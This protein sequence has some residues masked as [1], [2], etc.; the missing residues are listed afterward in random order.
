MGR[1]CGEPNEI[2]K[3]T[4]PKRITALFRVRAQDTV[5]T[6]APM[7]SMLA[8]ELDRLAQGFEADTKGFVKTGTRAVLYV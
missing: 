1:T 2:T 5:L 3:N 6:P 7:Q 8:P 4:H